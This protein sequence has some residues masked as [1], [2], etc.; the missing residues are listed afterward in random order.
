MEFVIASVLGG[1]AL[2]F[3]LVTACRFVT[4]AAAKADAVLCRAREDARAILGDANKH[5]DASVAMARKVLADATAKANDILADATA[6]ANDIL[7]D[8]RSFAAEDQRHVASSVTQATFKV[9]QSAATALAD[10]TQRM[11]ERVAAALAQVNAAVADAS[12]VKK[13]ES[14]DRVL[15]EAN[16][17]LAKANSV[18]V[19]A[20]AIADFAT[21]KNVERVGDAIAKTKNIIAEATARMGER[22]AAKADTVLAEAKAMVDTV[23][24]MKPYTS[25]MGLIVRE[26]KVFNFGDYGIIAV[27][28][29]TKTAYDLIQQQKYDLN[30]YRDNLHLGVMAIQ[31]MMGIVAGDKPLR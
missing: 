4:E 26:T 13:D 8:A 27:I 17:V 9:H 5:L 1:C 2:L 15:A 22:F 25:K 21:V 7:S 3:A 6:K 23:T 24:P 11:D 30:C 18:L 10:A 20:K 31:E 14:S 19:D 12:H 28:P 29:D 16:T